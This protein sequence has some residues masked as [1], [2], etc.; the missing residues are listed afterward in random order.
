[1]LFFKIIFNIIYQNN[2]KIQNKLSK[3]IKNNKKKSKLL[4]LQYK[5]AFILSVDAMFPG[6]FFP[7]IKHLQFTSLM[8]IKREQ[9]DA[10]L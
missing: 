3:T 8:G 7:L 9:Q 6:T 5:Q 1:L 10:R 2:L 4:K